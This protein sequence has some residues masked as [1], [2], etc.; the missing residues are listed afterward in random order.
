MFLFIPL[1]E[2]RVFVVQLCEGFGRKLVLDGDW[3]LMA[4]VE[5]VFEYVD[6]YLVKRNI[7]YNLRRQQMR[8]ICRRAL[9]CIVF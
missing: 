9:I 1:K 8:G 3:Q 7:F 6:K 2:P 5:F 4:E